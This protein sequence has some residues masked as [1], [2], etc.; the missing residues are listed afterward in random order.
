MADA[1]DTAQHLDELY[2]ESAIINALRHVNEE[3]PLI[4]NGVR[5]CLDCEMP[6]PL[7]RLENEPKAVRCVSC[8]TIK[9]KRF[10]KGAL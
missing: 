7:K 3:D 10:R 2:R 5:Y 6:I 8:Q 1:I 9:E 4:I